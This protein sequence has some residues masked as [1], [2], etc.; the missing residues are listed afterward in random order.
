M[1]II[2][3][4]PYVTH[5]FSHPPTPRQKLITCDGPQSVVV[6]NTWTPWSFCLF[7]LPFGPTFM[8]NRQLLF[9]VDNTACLSACVDGYSHFW[10][11]T[12]TSTTEN[13]RFY[14]TDHFSTCPSVIRFPSY[15]DLCHP[16]LAW[17]RRILSRWT[18]G[19]DHGVTDVYIISR[20]IVSRSF[21]I[22]SV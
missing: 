12:K 5:F 17:Y 4:D 22:V 18:S 20:L 21:S 15:D 10:S 6:T 7:S 9:F 11:V 3:R 14:D 16:H 19:L 13:A 8:R 1:H 2:S